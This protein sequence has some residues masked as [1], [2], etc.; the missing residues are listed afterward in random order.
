VNRLAH[1]LVPVAA[2]LVGCGRHA[3][4]V[5]GDV[6]LAGKPLTSGVVSFTPVATGPSAYGNVGG[7]GRYALQTG[8]GKGLDPG[9]YKVTV[10]AN[11]T[12]E[13]AARMGI[14]I[15]REGI[16]PLLTPLK[17][18]DVTTTP[19]MVT[20]TAGRQ[21]IDLA[22]EPDVAAPTPTAVPAPK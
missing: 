4:Y 14:T 7:D 19:L 10:A 17:Y 8:G 6:T 3:A 16:M 18:A 5:A 2:A 1:V 20:V 11:A 22:V 13:Q 12:A 9:D 21:E 15:G